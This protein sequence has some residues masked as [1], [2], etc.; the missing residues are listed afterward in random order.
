MISRIMDDAICVLGKGMDGMDGM[1]G[2]R[3]LTSPWLTGVPWVGL[4]TP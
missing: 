1:D 3:I 2:C 4:W